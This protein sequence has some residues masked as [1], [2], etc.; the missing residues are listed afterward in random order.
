MQLEDG[1]SAINIKRIGSIL[2]DLDY[3]GPLALGF[4]QTVC[5]KSLRV[6]KGF[7]V[8][9]QGGDKHFD[10][11]DQLKSLAVTFAPS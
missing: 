7:L 5:L 1:L 4:D 10:S 6:H 11:E 3:L 9:A 2:K 8:G